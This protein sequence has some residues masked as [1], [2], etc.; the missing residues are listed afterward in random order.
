MILFSRTILLELTFAHFALA[1]TFHPNC[2]IPPEGSN[3]VGGPNV[4]STLNIFWNAVY[5]MFVC[6]WAVQHRNLPPQ[7][8]KHKDPNYKWWKVWKLWARI[9]PTFW[10]KVKWMLVTILLPEFL[11]GRALGDYI[12]ANYFAKEEEQRNANSKWS[13]K[14][15]FY[16]NSGGFLTECAAPTYLVNRSGHHAKDSQPA[17]K[18]A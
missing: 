1:T 12:S 6:T 7:T 17:Y 11:V 18:S 14:H 13:T 2:T 10:T 4:R 8:Y 16:A 3:Y 9:P 15:G 5:T